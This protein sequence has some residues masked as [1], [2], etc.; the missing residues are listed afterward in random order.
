M[1]QSTFTLA[2]APLLLPDL[3]AA[4]IPQAGTT[5]S[6]TSQSAFS[7][8]YLQV[9]FSRTDIDGFDD[10]A[11][12]F[13]FLGSYSVSPQFFAF[14]GAGFSSVGVYIV[15]LGS[16]TIIGE[17]DL[18]STTIQA[19]FGFHQAI[20]VRTDFVADFAIGRVEADVNAIDYSDSTTIWAIEAGLRHMLVDQLELNGALVFHDGNDV[21]SEFG[22]A[23]GARFYA[24]PQLSVGLGFA[25]FDESNSLGLSL[26]YQW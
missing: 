6:A 11:D 2:I 13:S 25:A 8:S 17:D 19:G 22:A 24:T 26:R 16:G 23:L 4:S 7:Y 5:P 21:D 14:A 3:A 10:D 15:D 20:A 18:E 12:G 9:G 1:I